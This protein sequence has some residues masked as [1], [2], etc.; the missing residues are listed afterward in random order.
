[1]NRFTFIPEKVE[2]RRTVVVRRSTYTH[3]DTIR[4]HVPEELYPEFLPDPIKL[5][6]RFGEYAASFKLDQGQV[7]YIRKVIMKKGEFPADSYNE[8]IDFFKSI[9]KADNLKLVFLNK[10]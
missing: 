10:T 2:N 9:N 7:L 3:L 4:Y 1:M 5:K 8:L 6:S